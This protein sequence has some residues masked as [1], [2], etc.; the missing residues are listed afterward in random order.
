M[1][2]MD[3]AFY[4]RGLA[5]AAVRGGAD[6]SVTVRLDPKVK[7]T[8]AAIPADAWQTIEYTDAVFDEPTGRWISRAEVA[9]TP[10][11]AFAAQKKTDQVPG[12]LVVRR[13][14]DLNAGSKHGQETLFDSWRFHAFFTTSSPEVMGTVDADK[15]HRGHAII[16]QVQ[17]PDSEVRQSATPASLG[18]PLQWT[19]P[20]NRCPSVDRG[21]AGRGQLVP[22]P[23]QRAHLAHLLHETHPGVD[24]N[25][26][27][28]N[29]GVEPLRGHLTRA[30]DGIEDG[31]RRREREGELLHG[32]RAGFLQVVAA[33]VDGV[34][35]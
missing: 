12:R 35:P 9:E 13:I 28:P 14:P 1:A 15:T 31:R 24:E 7:A 22:E 25:E 29:Y 26:N 19:H 2:R 18:R 10:F 16:E 21:L 6:V 34:T 17:H 32:G 3:S 11:T 23:H 8:I 20:L 33:D 4:G 30:A 27:W 5:S